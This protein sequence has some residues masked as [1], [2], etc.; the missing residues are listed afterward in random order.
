VEVRANDGS[1]L[2]FDCGTGVRDL[3]VEL[4][5]SG[6]PITRVHLLIGHT[7]WDHIQGFPFFSLVFL[8]EVELN[9]FA[10]SG[11]QRNLEDAMSGQMQYAYFPVKLR[12][13]RSRVYFTEVGEGFFRLGDALVETRYLNHT[14]PTIAYRVTD[15]SASIAYVTDHEPFWNA[16]GP[17]FLHPGDRQHVEFLKNVDLVIHDAQYT[18]EEYKSK[19]G[20]GHSTIDYAT[21]VAMAA[22]A[23]RLALFHHDPTHDD[24]AIKEL[25]NRAR[26]RAA[27]LGS[28]IEIFAAAERH[29]LEIAGQRTVPAPQ[30]TSAFRIE[31]RQNIRVLVL[32]TDAADLV[33]VRQSLAEESCIVNSTSELASALAIIGHSSP[34][35]VIMVGVPKDEASSSIESL[36]NACGNP[37]LPVLFVTDAAE[38]DEAP[39]GAAGAT[40]YIARPF[41]VQ[42]LR[43]RVRVWSERCQAGS[44]SIDAVEEPQRSAKED[45][46]PAD[47]SL[48]AF[49]ASSSVL[50]SLSPAELVRLSSS[51]TQHTYFA[52]SDIVHQGELSD[53]VYVVLSGRVRVVQM[54]QENGVDIVLGEFGAGE[55][56]GEI[57]VLTDL[58]RSATVFAVDETKCLKILKGEL[59]NSLRNSAN[60]RLALQ[61]ILAD[62]LETT[63]SLVG[64]CAPD[65][66]TGLPSRR[67]FRDLYKRFASAAR[68]RKTALALLVLDIV[69]LKHINDEYGYATG[70]AVLRAVADTLNQLC[71]ETGVV[72]RYGGDEFA[73]LFLDPAGEHDPELVS[74]IRSRLQETA[75]RRSLPNIDCT[76]GRTSTQTPPDQADE[77]L[78]EADKDQQLRRL[79]VLQGR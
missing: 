18:S 64:R 17:R 7:H 65:A 28:E 58:P 53:S 46:K 12:D 44:N 50:G 42:M 3:G 19:R 76:I 15:A 77:L 22:G 73:V 6:T 43:C 54:G 51:G 41:S 52:G 56:F 70:D 1:V 71:G 49:L 30:G 78:Y 55:S 40:D 16:P 38:D 57:G 20:W 36:R 39:A 9:I 68:R 10:P 67:A 79:R 60:L 62:R 4:A 29:E 11:F 2:I 31:R 32:A 45:S 23:K 5:R 37:V 75:T 63:D 72:G 13:L 8:P 33:A 66:L 35:L 14:A 21:D 27:S 74:R 48:D 25:E 61:E 34:D 24:T 47:V 59:L 26:A 69:Q